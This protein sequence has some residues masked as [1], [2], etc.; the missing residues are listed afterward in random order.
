M[1]ALNDYVTPNEAAEMLRCS[2][3]TIT[4]YARLGKIEGFRMGGRLWLDPASLE[5]LVMPA[6]DGNHASR[7]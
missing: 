5:A 6:S 1:P 7:E 4:R 2:K 3:A